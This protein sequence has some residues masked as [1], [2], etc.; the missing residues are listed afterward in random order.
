MI[1][2]RT[3][4]LKSLVALRPHEHTASRAAPCRIQPSPHL[5]AQDAAPH[6]P[7]R[8][9]QSLGLNAYVWEKSMS[10]LCH[11]NLP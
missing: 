10:V 9:V 1:L 6:T 8:A 7:P 5:R 4:W 3:V 11:P 2:P